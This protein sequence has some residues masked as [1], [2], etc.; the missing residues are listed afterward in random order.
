MYEFL[1]AQIEEIYY[2]LVCWGLFPEK[3]KGCHRGTG[4]TG[5]ILYIDQH[6]LKDSKAKQKNIDMK[7]IYDKKHWNLNN[8]LSENIQNIGQT[9]EFS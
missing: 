1:T 4:G 7:W 2:S 9:L 8:G 3:E 6:I 5:D